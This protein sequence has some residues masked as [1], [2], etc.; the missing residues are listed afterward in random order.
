MTAILGLGFAM[1]AGLAASASAATTLLG[2]ALDMGEGEVRSY[3]DLD[4]DGRPTA[5]GAVL[6]ER[7][8]TGLPPLKNATSRCFDL[9][10]NGRIDGASECEGDLEFAMD[11]PREASSRADIPFQ[12]IGVNWNAEGH[13]PAVWSVPHFDFHFYIASRNEV[14]LI[15]VGGCIFFINCD[16]RKIALQPV[17]AKYVAPD[18]ADV[19]ATVS[20]MGNHL[21]DLRTPELADPQQQAFTHTWIYGAYGGRITFYEPMITLAYLLSRPDHCA[22]IR[23]PEAWA[24]AGYYPT[25]YCIRYHQRRGVYTVS[26]EGLVLRAAE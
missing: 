3:V 8:L 1:L 9:N 20:Q 10:D 12:W 19:E 11:L 13:P 16:D 14:A 5:I 2:E 24:Q 6:G 21:I 7:A 4:A 25:E 18:H 22:P 26:L 23:Q 17:P 15:R